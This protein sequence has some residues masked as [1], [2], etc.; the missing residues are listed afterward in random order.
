MIIAR[1]EALIAEKGMDEAIRRADAYENAGADAIL[2][3]SKKNTPDEI[4]EFSNKWKGKIP[5]VVVPTSYPSVKVNEL[6]SHKIK[7]VIYANQTL[8]VAHSAISR[9]VTEMNNAERISD[10]TEK[11]STMNEI[12]ELQKMFDIKNKEQDLENEL[13]KLG[14]IN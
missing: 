7:M 13:K 2:I 4:F 5:L 12:F 14:Y 6:I 9:L 10:V 1:T 11:M 8:R 3:H